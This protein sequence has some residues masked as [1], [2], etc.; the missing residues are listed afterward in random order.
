LC[1]ILERTEWAKVLAWAL[2]AHFE[3]QRAQGAAKEPWEMDDDES[4]DGRRSSIC[5]ETGLLLLT[6]GELK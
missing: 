3:G 1:R 4:W 6:E 2:A 5:G